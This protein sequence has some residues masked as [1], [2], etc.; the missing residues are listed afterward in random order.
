MK[1]D[2]PIDVILYQL[3]QPSTGT[4]LLKTT[5]KIDEYYLAK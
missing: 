4:S 5:K 1:A 3:I 2:I